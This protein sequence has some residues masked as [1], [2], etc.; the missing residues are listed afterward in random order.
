MLVLITYDV[1]TETEAGKKRLRKVA[2]PVSYTHLDVYKRQSKISAQ[3]VRTVM[4]GGSKPLYSHTAEDIQE[5][6]AMVLKN[7]HY[8]I[9]A[10]FTMTER[11]RDGDNTGKF[12]DIIKRRLNSGQCYHCLLYIS[13]YV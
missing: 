12:Q 8:V 13:R 7:V 9:E 2:K 1:N 5:R 4:M 11:A 10:H 6:A 3:N